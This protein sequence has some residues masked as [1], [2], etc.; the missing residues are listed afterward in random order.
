MGF[1]FGFDFMKY[2]RLSKEQFKILHEEFAIFLAAQS[3]DK[4]NWDKI[5]TKNPI[6]TDELLDQF[7]DIVWDKSLD[8]IAYLENRSDYHLFL[9]K[10]KDAQIDLILIRVDEDC[11]SLM[12]KDY[13]KWL[14][15]NLLDPR[16]AIFESSRSFTDDSKLEKFKLMSQGATV[17]D[18]KTYE[19]LK[20]FL[21]I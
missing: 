8:K 14:A 7:S 2:S 10:C 19:D 4:I 12:Q 20:S 13:K 3:I 5:K 9:F 16:V 15:K 18:G 17:S 11:P 6:L 21:S 1:F